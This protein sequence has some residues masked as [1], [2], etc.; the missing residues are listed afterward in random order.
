MNVAELSMDIWESVRGIFASFQRVKRVKNGG[1]RL[2]R[3]HIFWPSEA[4]Q[5]RPRPSKSR[6]CRHRERLGHSPES[7]I[8]LTIMFFYCSNSRKTVKT[9][10]WLE[11]KRN[12]VGFV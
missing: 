3:R 11:K 9:A 10:F 12:S 8:K 1:E 5:L 7:S 6:L 2:E 4:D